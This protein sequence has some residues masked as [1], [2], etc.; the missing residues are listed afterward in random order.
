M[1][2]INRDLKGV[3]IRDDIGDYWLLRGILGI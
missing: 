2:V 1:G 3:C